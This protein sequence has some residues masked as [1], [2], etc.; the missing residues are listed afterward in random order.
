MVLYTC[1]VCNYNTIRKNQYN[2]HLSTNKHNKRV[3]DL[4]NNKHIKS[5]YKCPYCSISLKDKPTLFS[6]INDYHLNDLTDIKAYGNETGNVF[7]APIT[8]NRESK[9]K[10]NYLGNT[11]N[12]GVTQNVET[13]NFVCNN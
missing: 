9:T 12:I 11:S 10:M 3:I 8:I 2:R 4:N 5:A 7:K 13:T 6:H 1:E